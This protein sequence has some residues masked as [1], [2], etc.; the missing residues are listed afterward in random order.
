[1]ADPKYHVV[2]WRTGDVATQDNGKAATSLT[3]EQAQRLVRADARTLRI[4]E[5]AKPSADKGDDDA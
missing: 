2:D 1:M 5:G 4:R 3:R